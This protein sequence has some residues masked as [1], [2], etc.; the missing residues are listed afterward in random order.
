MR[1]GTG[2]VTVQSK[3]CLTPLRLWICLCAFPSSIAKACPEGNWPREQELS[4]PIDRNDRA[5]GCGRVFRAGSIERGAVAR[6]VSRPE[7]RVANSLAEAEGGVPGGVGG[8][9]ARRV[10]SRARRGYD[11]LRLGWQPERVLAQKGNWK[12]Y[13]GIAGRL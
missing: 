11:Q 9:G 3:P 1:S 12:G 5:K 10:R 13:V 2:A 6:A 8:H 4:L 7:R